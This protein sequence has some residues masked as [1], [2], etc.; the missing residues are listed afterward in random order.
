MYR[1]KDVVVYFGHQNLLTKDKIKRLGFKA[2]KAPP[3]LLI[4]MSNGFI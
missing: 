2:E 1:E 3:K 4:F